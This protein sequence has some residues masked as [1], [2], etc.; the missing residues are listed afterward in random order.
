MVRQET[1]QAVQRVPDL[2]KQNSRRAY[3]LETSLGLGSKKGKG[4]EP[5]P[6]SL[7][8]TCNQEPTRTRLPH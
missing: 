5:A 6:N 7:L 8:N 3:V 2:F 4:G 1:G